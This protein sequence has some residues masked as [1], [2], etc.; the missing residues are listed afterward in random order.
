MAATATADCLPNEILSMIM[1]RLRK[2]DLKAARLVC[3]LWSSLVIRFLFNRV[4]ISP[5]ELDLE[6]FKSITSSQRLSWAVRELV[7]DASHFV[8]DLDLEFYVKRLLYQASKLTCGLKRDQFHSPDAEVNEFLEFS[9]YDGRLRRYPIEDIGKYDI[10]NRGY[11]YYTRQA[12][13]QHEIFG[14]GRFLTQLYTG[15]ST[16]A[17]IAR[18]TIT[19]R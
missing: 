2:S 16:L 18:V 14:S 17:N 10:V 8:L 3:R 19:D 7:Y 1:R 9:T 5:R 6:V 12:A 4:Y 11:D 15:L 13:E